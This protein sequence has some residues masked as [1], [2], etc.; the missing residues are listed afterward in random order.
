[1]KRIELKGIVKHFYF[2][3]KDF[4]IFQWLYNGKGYTK[5]FKILKGINLSISDGEIVGIL[6][7]NGAGKSTILKMIAG[8]YSPT[9]GS[10]KVNGK[11][12]SL[13][14]LGAGFNPI[15]SG[16]ENIYFKGNIIGL[17]VSELDSIIDDVIEFADIGEYMDM[18]LSSYSSG[19]AARLGFALAVM[20]DPEILII[21]EVFAVG[22]RDFQQKSRAKT[23]EFF[24]QGKTILFVSHSEDLIRTFCSR[25]IYLRDGFIQYDGAVEGGI[26]MYH[27]DIR[28]KTQNYAMVYEKM[29]N[30]GD[31]VD[32][33][34][35]IGRTHDSKVFDP[36]SLV[37]TKISIVKL[38]IE[39]R[40]LSEHDFCNIDVSELKEGKI[41]VRLKLIDIVGL[42]F[43]SFQFTYND[44][45]YDSFVF[46]GDD[47][48]FYD[49]KRIRI[50][51]LSRKLA[52][53]VTENY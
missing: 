24:E 33:F 42:G 34:F 10:I 40:K 26:E 19:M 31:Y 36:I 23:M 16:K 3:E 45:T 50:R 29:Q 8:I 53:D 52:I 51:H 46:K 11:V 25:V 2:F 35:D 30:H 4:K 22:D 15:L 44:K 28:K 32:F 27:A 7:A 20:V 43:I 48:V 37:N 21:D 1:M 41:C 38:A 6:G 17:S 5:E 47:T 18:P 9:S 14:E 39:Q 13:L 49:E 12:T